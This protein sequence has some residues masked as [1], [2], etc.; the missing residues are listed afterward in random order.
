MAPSWHSA[1][2][3]LPPTGVSTAAEL[4]T[5]AELNKGHTWRIF[6]KREKGT[7]VG[8]EVKKSLG[9]G[10]YETSRVPSLDVND[11]LERR[12]QLEAEEQRLNAHRDQQLQRVRDAEA[13]ETVSVPAAADCC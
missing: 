3:D 8:W 4:P 12:A 11:A 6:A 1:S 7:L 9:R 13:A 10:K 2:I 5:A